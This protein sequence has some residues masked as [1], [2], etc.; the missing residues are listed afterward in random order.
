VNQGSRNRCLLNASTEEQPELTLRARRRRR[1][2][3]G[4]G[5]TTVM[6]ESREGAHLRA[7]R[8]RDQKKTEIH[9]FETEMI[10]AKNE[11]KATPV[12]VT[13][14]SKAEELAGVPRFEINLV[15]TARRNEM[16][17][18]SK[19]TGNKIAVRRKEAKSDPVAKQ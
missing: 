8:A 1:D 18:I 9:A 17:R 15:W 6:G 14:T 4:C 16:A 13:S 2:G 3:A 19:Y 5:I 11:K 7:T 12:L 10:H